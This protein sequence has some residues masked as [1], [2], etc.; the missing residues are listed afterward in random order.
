LLPTS[1]ACVCSIAATRLSKV[2]A[3]ALIT[4][5]AAT[6]RRH[7]PNYLHRTVPPSRR[8]EK[9]HYPHCPTY[10]HA[11]QKSQP[12]LWITLALP[13]SGHRRPGCTVL[14]WPARGAS[15]TPQPTLFVEHAEHR[16]SSG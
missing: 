3:S 10:P 6:T 8:Q 5:C 12:S 15:S 9:P 4:H 14:V 7:R 13:H 2:R 11:V 16:A 1:A